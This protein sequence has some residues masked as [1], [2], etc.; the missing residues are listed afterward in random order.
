MHGNQVNY[1]TS[2]R[3]WNVRDQEKIPISNCHFVW[4]WLKRFPWLVCPKYLHD[5]FLYRV[6]LE[7]SV[8]G[9]TNKLVKLHASPLA[10]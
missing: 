4:S 6:Y 8:G 2:Q 9:N 5:A 10:L 7:S 1:L 3:Q